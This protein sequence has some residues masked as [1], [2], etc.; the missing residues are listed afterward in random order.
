GRGGYTGVVVTDWG[1]MNDRAAAY[2]AGL[3]LEMP[4]NGGASNVEVLA[5]LTEGRLD[6]AAVDRSV[7]RVRNLTCR[8]GTRSS[9]LPDNLYERHHGLARAA[10]VASG[11]LVK[12]NGLL[13]LPPTSTIA[14]I[15]TLA[16]VP[17]FQ[18][19]GSS[20]VNPTRVESLR[21]ALAARADVEY[22]PGY[23]IADEP[24]P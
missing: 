8:T 2:A 14:L 24:D 20:R 12:N 15:G 6:P 1:A 10:A 9:P 16:D 11:V 5:A 17:R 21:A 7:E 3:D 18:G 4:G 19:T 22:A 13:P 23:R